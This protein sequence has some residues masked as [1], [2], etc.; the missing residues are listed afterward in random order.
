MQKKICKWWFDYVV[1]IF[2][3]FFFLSS[4]KQTSSELII[5]PNEPNGQG[6]SEVHMLFFAAKQI[7]IYI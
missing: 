7:Y 6:F 4:E 5:Q 2:F 1:V 3:N